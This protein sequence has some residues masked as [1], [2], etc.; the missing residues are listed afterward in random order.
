MMLIM[1]GAS[2]G[3]MDDQVDQKT[4]SRKKV[5]QG[6]VQSLKSRKASIVVIQP[7]KGGCRFKLHTIMMLINTHLQSMKLRR[8][9]HLPSNLPQSWRD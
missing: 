9:L 1:L 3:R 6:T 4:A 7:A 8:G 5:H 2:S